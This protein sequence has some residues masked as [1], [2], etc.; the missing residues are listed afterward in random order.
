VNDLAVLLKENW[1]EAARVSFVVGSLLVVINQFDAIVGQQ[2]FHLWP[3]MLTYVVPFTVF[4]AGK[5][6]SRN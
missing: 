2:V 4:L 3:A 6:S 5:R 1:Y